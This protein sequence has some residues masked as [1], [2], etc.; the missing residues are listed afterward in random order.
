MDSSGELFT[1]DYDTYSSELSELEIDTLK[2]YQNVALNLISLKNDLNKIVGEI[3]TTS[4]QFTELE[5]DGFFQSVTNSNID[6]NLD[7]NHN[8]T[9]GTGTGKGGE[10][11]VSG[12]LDEVR[13]L[14]T[15]VGLISTLFKSSI[16]Q[17]VV[18]HEN[19]SQQ[20]QQQQQQIES[21]EISSTLD[22]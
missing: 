10:K 18:N 1:I 17:V 13:N 12:L 2:Q 3:S 9:G 14:E 21:G 15:K 7:G 19:V 20:Q 16:Y 5:N 22:L 4:L 6:S 8:S 11:I